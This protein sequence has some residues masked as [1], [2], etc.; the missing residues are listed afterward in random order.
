VDGDEARS[1]RLPIEPIAS[2][3]D[4]VLA[5]RAGAPISF[6]PALRSARDLDEAR[7]TA[8]SLAEA[9]AVNAAP[10]AESTLVRF[11][12][13]VE[14]GPL[15]AHAARATLRELKAVG[16]DLRA[17]RIALTGRDRGPELW[18]VLVA[19]G[20]EEAARRASMALASV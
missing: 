3:S 14:D 18:A 15:D 9:P 17:L 20:G 10:E 19:L 11:L 5:A 8:A 6:V 16:G 13:L 12:E 7:D 1:D 2:L 4:E